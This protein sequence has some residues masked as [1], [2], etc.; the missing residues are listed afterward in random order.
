MIVDMC[1]VEGARRTL[2]KKCIPFLSLKCF[3]PWR[4]SSQLHIL[5]FE[6]HLVVSTGLQLFHSP[7]DVLV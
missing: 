5:F 6:H 7:H 3:P 1:S 4:M 2:A